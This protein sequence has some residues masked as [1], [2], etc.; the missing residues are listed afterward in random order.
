MLLPHSQPEFARGLR[1]P[2]LVPEQGPSPLSGEQRNT[3]REGAVT[4]QPLSQLVPW[5]LRAAHQGPRLGV[6]LLGS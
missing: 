6:P 1:Q 3:L 2:V 4:H 5:A